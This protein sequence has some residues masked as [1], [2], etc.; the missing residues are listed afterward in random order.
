M[1]KLS[2][3][4]KYPPQRD[5]AAYVSLR[6]ALATTPQYASIALTSKKCYMASVRASFLK[7][8]NDIKFLL[9]MS[10]LSVGLQCV[11]WLTF[12]HMK[13]LY[14]LYWNRKPTG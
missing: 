1:R 2:V 13:L 4:H 14:S 5:M 7:A 12:D 6:R 9:H 8:S 11:L 10:H 3:G